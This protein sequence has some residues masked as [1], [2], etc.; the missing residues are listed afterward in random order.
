MR[1]G[2]I[3]S[4]VHEKCYTPKKRA[5]P[6]KGRCIP[7]ELER[8]FGMVGFRMLLLTIAK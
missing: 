5:K 1:G 3:V 4:L 7:D 8:R 2:A 6:F